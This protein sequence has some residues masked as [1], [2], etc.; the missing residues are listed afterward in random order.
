MDEKKWLKKAAAGDAEAFE[1]LVLQYP[2]AANLH[3]R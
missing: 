2:L 3:S 1:Q